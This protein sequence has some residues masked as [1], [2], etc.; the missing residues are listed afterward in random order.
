M[1]RTLEEREDWITIAEAENCSHL[2]I[3]SRDSENFFPLYVH[4]ELDLQEDLQTLEDSGAIVEEVIDIDKLDH[5]EADNNL[6][7]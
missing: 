2:I 4:E 7:R 3:A 6:A 1:D 5:L